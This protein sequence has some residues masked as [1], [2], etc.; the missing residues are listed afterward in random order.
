MLVMKWHSPPLRPRYSGI[1][2]QLFTRF[3]NDLIINKL[4]AYEIERDNSRLN[5][6]LKC[7]KQCEK[8]NI[9]YGEYNQI[10]SSV[11][12]VSVLYPI[13]FNLSINDLFFFTE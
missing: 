12:Q 5:S 4:A 8:I 10:I 13:C 11:S 9:I 3:S 7:R 6:Y 1:F 2:S